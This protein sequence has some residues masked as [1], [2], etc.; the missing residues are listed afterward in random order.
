MTHNTFQGLGTE[1]F[2]DYLIEQA[3]IVMKKALKAC[4][5][6]GM[7]LPDASMWDYAVI[8]NILISITAHKQLLENN[9]FIANVLTDAL[10]RLSRESL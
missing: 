6:S 5:D 2:K 10:K 1:T 7:A 8:S 3:R 4:A 9:N